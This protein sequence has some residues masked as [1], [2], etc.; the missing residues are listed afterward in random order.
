MW[1]VRDQV[2]GMVTSG[3]CKQDAIKMNEETFN[4]TDFKRE[5]AKRFIHLPGEND[6]QR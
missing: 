6:E 1:L 2:T 5:G 3:Y 4:Q